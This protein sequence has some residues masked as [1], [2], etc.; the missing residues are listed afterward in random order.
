MALHSNK[1]KAVQAYRD[2][3]PIKEIMDTYNIGSGALYYALDKA[4][5]PRRQS[6]PSRHSGRHWKTKRQKRRALAAI[7]RAVE[8]EFADLWLH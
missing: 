1:L 6:H 7:D 2:G 4:E 5:V 8:E 3:M